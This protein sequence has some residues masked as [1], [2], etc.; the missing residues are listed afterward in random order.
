LVKKDGLREIA[1]EIEGDLKREFN[2]FYDE[3]GAI[4]RRYRRQDEVGTPFCITVDYTTKD[5]GTVTV[6]RRD[7][8][9]QERLRRDELKDW[10]RA[11]VL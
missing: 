4:G 3:G 6:R 10:L 1:L 9:A 2:V 7:D 11:R 8:C 5:D